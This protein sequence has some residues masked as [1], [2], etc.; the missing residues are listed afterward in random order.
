MKRV[1]RRFPVPFIARISADGDVSVFESVG[2]KFN[3]PKRIR[4]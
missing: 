4:A 2:K 3:P 1:L